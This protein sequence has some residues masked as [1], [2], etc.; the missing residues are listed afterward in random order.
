MVVPYN[1][2]WAAR[3]AADSS[4][5]ALH[6]LIEPTPRVSRA[7]TPS[8]VVEDGATRLPKHI[9]MRVAGGSDESIALDYAVMD[10]HWV[11]CTAR[12]VRRCT[13]HF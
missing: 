6:L 7:C 5:A 12:S 13:W 4:E 11:S 3:Y 2:Y 9:E 8:E 1:S 10:G